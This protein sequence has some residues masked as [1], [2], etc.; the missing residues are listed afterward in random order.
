MAAGAEADDDSGAQK[1]DDFDWVGNSTQ[2]FSVTSSQL[3]DTIEL[4]KEWKD[5]LDYD[6]WG[7]EDWSA[8]RISPEKMDAKNNSKASGDHNL[9]HWNEDVVKE[10]AESE[11]YPFVREPEQDGDVIVSQGMS[12]IDALTSQLD[13]PL[14]SL[15]GEW[16]NM[17]YAGEKPDQVILSNNGTEGFQASLFP[18]GRTDKAMS[19]GGIVPE[20]AENP[21]MYDNQHNNYM[22]ALLDQA[23]GRS[24]STSKDVRNGELLIENRIEAYRPVDWQNP[25]EFIFEVSEI[26]R[27]GLQV[28]VEWDIHLDYGDRVEESVLSYSEKSM[29]TKG[30]EELDSVQEAYEDEQET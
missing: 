6:T 20:Y 10:L 25:D 8:L 14:T 4:R 5:E 24:F 9:L 2:R 11:D 23:V 18:S 27:E 29:Y 16:S 13:R 1:Q 28:N 22:T 17:V 3:E 12:F 30:F 7:G 15:E 21:D 26:E 19:A